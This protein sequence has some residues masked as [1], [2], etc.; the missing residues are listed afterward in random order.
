ML[1]FLSPERE[2]GCP[3]V[4]I[5][6]LFG[7]PV[8]QVEQSSP[9]AYSNCFP[10]PNFPS[11]LQFI[12]ISVWK[13]KKYHVISA[14]CSRQTRVTIDV[15]TWG[16]C[17]VNTNRDC[18]SQLNKWLMLSF[19]MRGQFSNLS[20]RGGWCNFAPFHTRVRWNYA[21]GFDISRGE[22]VNQALNLWTQ[23]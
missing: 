2:F 6:F 8:K 7:N 15:D 20:R 14:S 4:R 13:H 10:C 16:S 22:P 19:F 21:P 12:N 9:V 3:E 1:L 18:S 17:Q 11:T 5:I 23:I